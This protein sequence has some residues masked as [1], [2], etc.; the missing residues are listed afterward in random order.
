LCLLGVSM[1]LKVVFSLDI[2]VFRIVMA[3][4]LIVLGIR[5]L[6]GVSWKGCPPAGNTILFS[7][8]EMKGGG[9]DRDFTVVFGRGTLD[10]TGMRP[11]DHKD[12]IEFTT[13]FGAGAL[14]LDPTVPTKVTVSSAFAG[15]HVPDGTQV[16]FGSY[17]YRTPG[18]SDD[19]PFLDVRA[20]VV[21]GELK[22]ETP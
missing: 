1:I 11:E 18:Q 15:A 8:S 6:L 7:E 19:A 13:V 2:P 9:T 10:L 4:V 21:F 20:T 12:P 14:R 3:G 22:V 5:L 17:V 16:A